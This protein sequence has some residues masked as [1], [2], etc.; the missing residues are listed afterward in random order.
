MWIALVVLIM[1]ILI[2]IG[3]VTLLW[4][5]AAAISQDPFDPGG[6]HGCD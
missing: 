5:F 3:T 1:L 6:P 4:A 2:V